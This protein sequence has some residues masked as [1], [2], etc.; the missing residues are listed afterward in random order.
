LEMYRLSEDGDASTA[1]HATARARQASP[2]KARR[3]RHRWQKAR[4]KP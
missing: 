2:P 1:S 3:R 4:L